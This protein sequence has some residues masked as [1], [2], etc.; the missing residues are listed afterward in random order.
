MKDNSGLYTKLKTHKQQNLKCYKGK[1][2]G[3]YSFSLAK[4][5]VAL[6]QKVRRKRK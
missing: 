5:S 6:Y 4:I 1:F 3:I 2:L